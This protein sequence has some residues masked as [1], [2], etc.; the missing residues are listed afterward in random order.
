MITSGKKTFGCLNKFSQL[1]HLQISGEV[2]R[3]CML[4]TRLKKI[5]TKHIKSTFQQNVLKLSGVKL[6]SSNN[7]PGQS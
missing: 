7:N 3:L 6:E 4:I 5:T 1:L 2:R